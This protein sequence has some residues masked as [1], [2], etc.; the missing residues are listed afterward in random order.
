MRQTP[1]RRIALEGVN[2]VFVHDALQIDP[3]N[4]ERA[5]DHVRAN[6]AADRKIAARISQRNVGGV[7]HDRNSDLF[8]RA[9]R[10]LHSDGK[11]QRSDRSAAENAKQKSKN[12]FSHRSA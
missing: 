9:V 12:R 1:K 11:W 5:N 2:H 3:G 10:N 7:V 8:L 6:A 4:A